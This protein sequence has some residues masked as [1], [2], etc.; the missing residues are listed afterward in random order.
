MTREEL[1]ERERLAFVHDVDEA[2]VQTVQAINALAEQAI[3]TSTGVGREA[4]EDAKM[5]AIHN[6]HRFA[7]TVRA[8]RENLARLTTRP[9]AGITL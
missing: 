2:L 4:L 3:A 5:R 6:A 7:R 1:A 9:A 8:D